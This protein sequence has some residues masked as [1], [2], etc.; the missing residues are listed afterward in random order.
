MNYDDE[1]P[2]CAHWSK[3]SRASPNSPADSWGM[4]L[5]LQ[6]KHTA[7]LLSTYVG[8]AATK[9]SFSFRP[10]NMVEVS[11]VYHAPQMR[12]G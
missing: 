8:A 6:H 9:E 10:I 1:H 12:P 2:P 7:R 3:R 4:N 11:D 5:S